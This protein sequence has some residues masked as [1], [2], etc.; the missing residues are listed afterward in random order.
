MTFI[1]RKEQVISFDLTQYGKRLLAKGEF[2]PVYYAFYDDDIIY[3]SQYGGFTEPQNSSSVRILNTIRPDLQTNFEGVETNI[4]NLIK[5]FR[6]THEEPFQNA[7]EKQYVLGAELGNMALDATTIPAWGI[8]VLKGE[9]SGVVHYKLSSSF[10]CQRIPQITLMPV[11]YKT[12]IKFGVPP[13]TEENIF[14]NLV[15]TGLTTDKFEDGSYLN[16]LDDFIVMQVNE[17]NVIDLKDNFS[18]EV[19]EKDI[20]SKTGEEVLLPLSFRKRKTNIENDILLDDDN[21]IAPE[22]DSSYVEYFFEVLT[23][24]EIEPDILCQYGAKDKDSGLYGDKI[25]ECPDVPKGQKKTN[26]IYSPVLI[27]EEE[28]K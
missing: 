12:E 4:K 9:I 14:E 8:D 27:N 26:N 25:V 17:D 10:S 28:C 2:S 13:N 24:K 21:I 11:S 22:L 5:L 3:D 7:K 23:D 20:D 15:E 1:N 6:E 16:I 19:F 18:L